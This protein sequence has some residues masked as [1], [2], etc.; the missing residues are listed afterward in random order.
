MA[1][2]RCLYRTLTDE[3]QKFEGLCRH[4][5]RPAI[6]KKRLSLISNG[7]VRYRLKTWLAPALALTEF[8]KTEAVNRDRLL[9]GSDGDSIPP[10]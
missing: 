6:V 7:N 2:N 10:P 9:S 1:D 5:S 8:L 4:I 3:C